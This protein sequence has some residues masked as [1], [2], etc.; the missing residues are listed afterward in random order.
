[1]DNLR[2]ECEWQSCRWVFNNYDHMQ[3]HVREH[4]P[5]VHVIEDEGKGKFHSDSH[6]I[7]YVV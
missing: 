4:I 1:M 5:E 2:M 3:N 7:Y 6:I